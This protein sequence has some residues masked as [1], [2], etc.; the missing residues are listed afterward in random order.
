M[1]AITTRTSAIAIFYTNSLLMKKQDIFC[2]I[3]FKVLDVKFQFCFIDYTQF[4][5]SN[6]RLSIDRVPRLPTNL[7]NAIVFWKVIIFT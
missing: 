3:F 4:M 1:I 6:C 5:S 2:S 7:N